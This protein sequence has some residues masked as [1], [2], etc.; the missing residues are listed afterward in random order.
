MVLISCHGGSSRAKVN[1]IFVEV[2]TTEIIGIFSIGVL[3][4]TWT[5]PG[6]C[7]GTGPSGPG[8]NSLTLSCC[9]QIGEFQR[10]VLSM[11]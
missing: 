10:E 3:F 11:G 6:S 2:V 4:P 7:P 5:V 8:S 1:A 9:G